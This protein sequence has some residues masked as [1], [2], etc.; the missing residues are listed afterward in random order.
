M[1]ALFLV[2]RFALPHQTLEKVCDKVKDIQCVEEEGKSVFTCALTKEGAEALVGWS[3][4]GRRRRSSGGEGPTF[5]Y[6]GIL[7]LTATVDGVIE[8]IDITA[9]TSGSFLEDND[10]EITQKTSI[11]LKELGKIAVEV[12]EDVKAKFA[13]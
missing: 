12:P 8:K 1:R 6:S 4:F 13:P 11:E 10:F 9:T 5:E 2:G 3:R 7:I